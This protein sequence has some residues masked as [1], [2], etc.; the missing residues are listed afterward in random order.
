MRGYVSDWVCYKKLYDMYVTKDQLSNTIKHY[1]TT[2]ITIT[3][4]IPCSC[5]LQSLHNR[6]ILMYFVLYGFEPFPSLHL[7]SNCEFWFEF[8]FVLYGFTNGARGYALLYFVR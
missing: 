6:M 5:Y 3:I 1:L 8:E 2:T 4:T 7:L